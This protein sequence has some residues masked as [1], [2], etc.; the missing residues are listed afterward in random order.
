MIHKSNG[1]DSGRCEAFTT[2][3]VQRLIFLAE[4]QSTITT[5]TV[6]QQTITTAILLQ[7][8]ITAVVQQTS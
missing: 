4:L 2:A 1:R 5:T 7:V 8:I 3:V 6:V